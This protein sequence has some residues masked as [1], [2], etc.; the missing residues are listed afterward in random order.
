VENDGY[1]VLIGLVVHCMVNERTVASST[2][3]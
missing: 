1:F 3:V 2:R